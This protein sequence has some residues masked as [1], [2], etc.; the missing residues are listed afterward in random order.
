MEQILD[1][2]SP[3]QKIYKDR[4]IWVGTFLGGPLAAGYLI[5]ENFTAF[6]EREKATRTWIYAII[7]TI[8]IF[9]SLFLIPEIEKIPN[10]VFP[11]AYTAIAYYLV[12]RF[13]G[14]KITSHVNA[15]GPC[16]SWWRTLSVSIIA[17]AI[18]VIPVMGFVM[19]SESSADA[20]LTAR[21]Y[22]VMKH[23]IIFD[24]SN[25]SENEV[26]KLAE[27]LVS[28]A[29]FDDQVT[30]YVYAEKVDEQYDLSISVLNGIAG[31]EEAL[32][33]FRELR[34]ELQT[35]FPEHK[36]IFSLVVDDL[37]NVVKRIE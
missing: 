3:P 37:D 27:G 1:I 26:D 8:V 5:A 10:Q 30:K 24:A 19:Y 11:L 17:L 23:E 35:L 20:S 18:T 7:S 31:D 32:A 25:I 36:V 14:E 2:Q 13:Q 28:T 22:G 15:G 4:A 12:Q 29:F 34:A 21:T 6:D 9:G 16:H 33:P